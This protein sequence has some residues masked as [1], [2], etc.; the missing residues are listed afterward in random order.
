M[1]DA[2]DIG[3]IHVRRCLVQIHEWT[4]NFSFAPIMYH[5]IVYTFAMWHEDAGNNLAKPFE[6]IMKVSVAGLFLKHMS[7]A[8]VKYQQTCIV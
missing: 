7:T 6:A 1:R 4:D 2:E 3:I 8:S 5:I